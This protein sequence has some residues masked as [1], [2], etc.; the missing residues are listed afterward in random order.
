MVRAS[1]WQWERHIQKQGEI[2]VLEERLALPITDL[3]TYLHAAAPGLGD[4]AY[5]RFSVRGEFDHQHEVLL[6]NR[7]LDGMPGFHLITPLLI[8]GSQHRILVNRGFI[9]IDQGTR[10][11][12][13]VF[14]RS[15]TVVLT[16]VAKASARRRFLA[17]GDTAP[18]PGGAWV[19]SWIRV[20]V[21]LMATQL[22]YPVLPFFLEVMED[23][24]PERAREQIV[25][26][27]AGREEL[28]F[29]GFREVT[30]DEPLT[31]SVDFPIPAFDPVIPPGRHL[32]YVYEWLAMAAATLLICAI[33]QLR[34]S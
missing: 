16:A 4:V 8:E 14:E 32:G 7:S 23:T 25:R 17:P 2:K 5:R 3:K 18:R 20:D 24:D 34:R 13:R 28:L 15:G 30:R 10:D 27:G 12:R 6:R 31:E 33:I 29:M 9:P 22:P 1:V 26:S 11:K 21:P 19:D